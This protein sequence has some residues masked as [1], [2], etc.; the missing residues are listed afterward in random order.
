[1]RLNTLDRTLSCSGLKPGVNSIFTPVT[2]SK[3]VGSDVMARHSDKA[4][5]IWPARKRGWLL[6]RA[7]SSVS[8]LSAVVCFVHT[9]V[10]GEIGV[11]FVSCLPPSWTLILGDGL[12]I[13]KNHSLAVGMAGIA[14]CLDAFDC[15][16]NS[17]CSS[18]C[19]L[20]L[21]V[22]WLTW[23]VYWHQKYPLLVWID[24]QT[25]TLR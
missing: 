8:A 2:N 5:T 15:A 13:K 20:A 17:S 10:A 24:P 11:R 12:L 23:P 25:S 21:V 16:G 4:L 3:I 6:N 22:A 19:E 14:D 18:C 7:G 1:M 9:F